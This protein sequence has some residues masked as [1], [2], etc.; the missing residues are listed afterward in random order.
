MLRT[1]LLF[2]LASVRVHAATC[3][4]LAKLKLPHTTV[5]RAEMVAAGGSTLP[6]TLIQNSWAGSNEVLPAEL[7]AFCRVLLKSRPV[8]DSEIAVEVRLPIK[9][10]NGRFLGVGNGG[11]AGQ[12]NWR[13]MS[14]PLSRG[15]AVA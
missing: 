1:G 2:L 5:E 6:S 3:E 8:T 14:R 11:S 4:D 15:Y 13:A 10:W 7:P 9:G 12:I